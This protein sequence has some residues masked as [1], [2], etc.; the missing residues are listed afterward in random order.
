VGCILTFVALALLVSGPAHAQGIVVA[1]GWAPSYM[2]ADGSNTTAPVGAMF[3]VA[4]SVLP[5]AKIV[6]DL[7]YLHKDGGTMITGTV[8]VRLGAPSVAKVAPFVEGLVGLG[9]L[10][11]DGGSNN[12]LA[13][14]VGVGVDIKAVPVVGLRIQGNYFRTTQMGVTFNQFR[15]GLGISLSPGL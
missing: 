12:G 9:H 8:G 15:L 14:G 2:T 13:Y 1:A 5:F 6:G 7:G 3:N 4:A 10:S 11:A